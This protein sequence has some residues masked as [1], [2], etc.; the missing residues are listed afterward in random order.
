MTMPERVKR[1]FLISGTSTNWLAEPTRFGTVIAHGGAQL[2]GA[3]LLDG[4]GQ[5][6]NKALLEH[7][8]V[9]RRP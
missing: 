2:V 8:L 9:V 5:K 1:F 6:V 7:A 4:D 3:R